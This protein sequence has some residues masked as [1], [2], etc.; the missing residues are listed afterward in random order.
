MRII[1]TL[2]VARSSGRVKIFCSERQQVRT[3]VQEIRGNG[4]TTKQ[5]KTK[6]QQQQQL[7]LLLLLCCG[8]ITFVHISII[9]NTKVFKVSYERISFLLN[10]Y[11]KIEKIKLK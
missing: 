6:Q 10:V 3:A 5:N 2:S 9:H 7:L 11:K 4:T 1:K 8:N